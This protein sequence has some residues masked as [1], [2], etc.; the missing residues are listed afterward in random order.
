M[1]KTFSYV[2]L[3]VLLFEQQKRLEPNS[4][5]FG[6]VVMTYIGRGA[7]FITTPLHTCVLELLALTALALENKYAK[8]NLYKI[9]TRFWGVKML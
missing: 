7:F 4:N 1:Q 5:L 6:F 9:S 8:P 3:G 2:L